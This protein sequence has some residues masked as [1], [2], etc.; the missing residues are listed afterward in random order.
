MYSDMRYEVI[1][2]KCSAEELVELVQYTFTAQPWRKSETRLPNFV[3]LLTNGK[4]LEHQEIQPAWNN[5][6]ITNTLKHV[7]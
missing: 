3:C 1:C 5:P 7:I 2:K 6:H 4:H